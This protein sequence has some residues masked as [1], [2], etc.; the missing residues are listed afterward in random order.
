MKRKPVTI[1]LVQMRCDGS[2]K[3]NFDKAV[4]L[5][6]RAKEAGATI[7]VLPELFQYPYFC[8]RENDDTAKRFAEPIPG[9]TTERLAAVAKKLAVVLVGGSLLEA[10]GTGVIHNTAL[11]FDSDGIMLG[12]Y[13]KSHLPMDECYFEQNYFSKGDT[14]VQVFSTAHAKIAVQICYDQWFPEMARIAT[15]LGAEILVYPSA[16]GAIDHARFSDEN[17]WQEM[18]LNAH[19]GHAA[20]NNVFVAVANRVGHEGRITFWGG[21][22]V[23][24]P[25]S[26]LLCFGTVAEEIVLAR[27]DLEQVRVAQES[28]G[29]LRNR[30]TDLFTQ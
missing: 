6:E 13:R 20:S 8:Q 15:L 5:V 29:F 14:G 4:A 28:W 26:R 11:V 17:N 16:I 21:S 23:I 30:R 24:D 19:L 1:G 3:D 25:T 9:P 2:P 12:K 18:W 27:C 7:V 22:F 10:S